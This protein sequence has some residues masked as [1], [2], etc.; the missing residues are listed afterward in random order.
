M[1]NRGQKPSH[2]SSKKSGS[3]RGR[4]PLGVTVFEQEDPASSGKDFGAERDV[5]CDGLKA[6]IGEW[7][8]EKRP[9]GGEGG[10][11][12]MSTQAVALHK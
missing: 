2:A 5:C 11:V 7:K 6:R 10:R 8:R 3:V 1:P 9:F 4:V 12:R